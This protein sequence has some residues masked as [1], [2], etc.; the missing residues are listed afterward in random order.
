MK[1]KL[2]A[3]KGF[4]DEHVIYNDPVIF[5]RLNGFVVEH[6]GEEIFL[7][8]DDIN[9]LEISKDEKYAPLLW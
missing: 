5:R 7:L 9:V 1:F 4:C 6:N 3:G 8:R 2:K